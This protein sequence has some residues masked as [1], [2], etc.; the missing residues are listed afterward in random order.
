M[1]P[2]S[3]AILPGLAALW[4]ARGA[5]GALPDGRPNGNM[6]KP[7]GI[8][9]VPLPEGPVVSRN[10]TELPPYNTTYFFDQLIDH[11]NP[12]LGTFKQRFWFTYE[13]YEPG[14]M[15]P[16]LMCC[17]RVDMSMC[18]GGPII[19]TTPGEAN[20]QGMSILDQGTVCPFTYNHPGYTAYLTN[21]TFNG[22]LAQ[23]E[24]GATIVLEHRSERLHSSRTMY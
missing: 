15:I 12:S 2:F 13:F 9:K 24:S 5:S 17:I 18:A 22:L 7:P 11:K 3:W 14:D 6:F 10:G 20:A 23:Q 4:L 21:T 8:P 16:F 19:L 1:A